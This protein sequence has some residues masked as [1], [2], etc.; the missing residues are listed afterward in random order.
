VLIFMAIFLAL[1]AVSKLGKTVAPDEATQ[2]VKSARGQLIMV[3]AWIGILL[4]ADIGLL[5]LAW[6]RFR[7]D[8]LIEIR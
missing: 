6:A 4:V 5:L 2:F 7:R 1:V 3:G 8:R